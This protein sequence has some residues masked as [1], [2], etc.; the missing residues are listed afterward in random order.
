MLKPLIAG[1]ALV[2]FAA[3]AFADGYEPSTA[4]KPSCCAQK[5][6]PARKAPVKLMGGPPVASPHRV[7]AEVR[8]PVIYTDTPV[9]VEN[10]VEVPVDRTVY[11][12]RPVEVQVDRPVYVERRIEVPVDRPVYVP[13]DRRIYVDRPV[14]VERQV[15][16]VVDRPVYVERQRQV[17]YDDC[18]CDH[19]AYSSG[20][21]YSASSY[22][23]QSYQSASREVSIESGGW[24]GGVGYTDGGYYGGGGGG[25]FQ[26]GGINGSSGY[27]QQTYANASAS[28]SAYSY[29][30]S[31]SSRGHGGGHGCG[32]GCR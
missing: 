10:R 22:E 21:S 15:E 2:L 6:K 24:S 18:R 14:Y 1:L 26:Y 17:Y 8:H 7:Q 16:V 31:G 4:R 27:R 9:Y 23:A 12:D 3:P 29:S 5:P 11:V 30:R 28:A 32:G 25:F 19:R 20:G 13:V